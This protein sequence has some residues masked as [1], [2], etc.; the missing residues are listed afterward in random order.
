MNV[1]LYAGPGTEQNLEHT[2]YA[3]RSL[4]GHAY[5]VL[6]ITADQLADAPWT[7]RAV[8]L[9]VPGGRDLPYVENLK[10]VPNLRIKK[11]VEGGGKYLG[12]CAGSLTFYFG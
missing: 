2:R 6:P 10:G 11:W 9:V 3:L 5:D 8:A 1:L 7:D 4:L 12:I